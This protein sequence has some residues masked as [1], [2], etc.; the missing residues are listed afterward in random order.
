MTNARYDTRGGGV[1]TMG[2]GGLVIWV[3]VVVAGIGRIVSSGEAS[4]ARVMNEKWVVG[5]AGKWK[6]DSWW[7]V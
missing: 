6:R 4:C 7:G 5:G 3:V 2:D 1:E